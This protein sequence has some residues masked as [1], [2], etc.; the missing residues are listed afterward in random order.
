VTL[1]NITLSAEEAAITKARDYAR[2]RNT[3]LNF[4]FREWLDHCAQ[5]HNSGADNAAAFRA[6][7]RRLDHVKSHGPYTRDDMNER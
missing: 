3:T 7:M 1:K 4:L 5:Q 6:M 2:S